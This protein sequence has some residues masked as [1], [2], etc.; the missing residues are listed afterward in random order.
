MSVN[1]KKLKN[2]FG[3][4]EQTEEHKPVDIFA[5]DDEDSVSTPTI[6]DSY[7]EDDVD[8]LLPTASVQRVCNTKPATPQ[9]FVDDINYAFR[10]QSD[11]I[12]KSQ[13][14]VQ[15]A[16]QNAADEGSAR[17]I[18]VAANALNTATDNIQKLLSMYEKMQKLTGK[19]NEPVQQSGTTYVQNQ[20]IYQG[21][22][23]KF[24][25]DLEDGLIDV[26]DL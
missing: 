3:V 9:D 17:D 14:L 5:E 2:L 19:Q 10:T 24:I 13:Q 11:L 6:Y 21:T 20:V 22:T 4:N 15:L 25:K 16:L 1:Q 23:S 8:N 7:T 12:N 18:E 26:D